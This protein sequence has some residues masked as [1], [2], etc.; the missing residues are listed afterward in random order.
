[1][2]RTFKDKDRYEQKVKIRKA[3]KAECPTCDGVHDHQL[4]WLKGIYC[5]RC[6]GTMVEVMEPR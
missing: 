5:P 2:G 4:G 3:K 6:G 1:M